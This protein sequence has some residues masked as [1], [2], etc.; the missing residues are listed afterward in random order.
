MKQRIWLI[1]TVAA[2]FGLQVPICA[3]ACLQSPAADAAS[4]DQALP[5]CHEHSSDSV[6]S[7]VPN[8]ETSCCEFAYDA[9]IIDAGTSLNI[10]SLDVTPLAA[11]WLTA[12]RASFVRAVTASANLPPPDILLL[13]AILII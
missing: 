11:H 10:V 9:I 5:P 2:L 6:P 12:T 3:L 1:A 7:E 13:N 4:V 8:S